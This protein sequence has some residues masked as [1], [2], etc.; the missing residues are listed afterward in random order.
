MAK[1]LLSRG[2]VAKSEICARET[3]PLA[4]GGMRAVGLGLFLRSACLR[5]SAGFETPEYSNRNIG[6]RPPM[7]ISAARDIEPTAVVHR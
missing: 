6:V 1:P 7:A 4:P 5:T 2:I 3:P